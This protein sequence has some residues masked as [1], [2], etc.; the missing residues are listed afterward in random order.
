MLSLKECRRLAAGR[1]RFWDALRAF[2]ETVDLSRLDV[3]PEAFEGVRDP[4]S[5]GK[6]SSDST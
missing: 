2:R 1:E 3:G 5:G 4:S 6:T